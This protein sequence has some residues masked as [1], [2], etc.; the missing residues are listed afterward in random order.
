MRAY[1]HPNVLLADQTYYK[2]ALHRDDVTA[3]ACF[4][5]WLDR[6]DAE[7]IVFNEHKLLA[8]AARRFPDMAAR[9]AH[10]GVIANITRQ[11]NLRAHVAN[12]ELTRLTSNP[13]ISRFSLVPIGETHHRLKLAA[14]DHTHMESIELAVKHA[15]LRAIVVA[16][17]GIGYE[18]I[19][20]IKQAPWQPACL[21]ILQSRTYPTLS[22]RVVGLRKLP[23]HV[24]IPDH[25]QL[26]CIM[27]AEGYRDFM[28]SRHVRLL[29]RRDQLVFDMAHFMST[30]FPNRLA[31]PKPAN[32]SFSKII[33]EVTGLT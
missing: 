14:T 29:R 24:P 12:A 15:A 1:L 25:F 6:F 13:S 5:L 3:R 20:P 17:S 2:A 4:D 7:K 26:G 16:L 31:L 30:A 21:A 33:S 18:L 8:L 23:E 32:R 9:S 10:S 22:V 11:A 28:S 19:C 27:T